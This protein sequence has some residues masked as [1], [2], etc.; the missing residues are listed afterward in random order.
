MING[1]TQS[2]TGCN[3]YLGGAT[4]NAGT[5][6]VGNGN[7]NSATFRGTITDSSSI[8]LFPSF[9][10]YGVSAGGL[11]DSEELTELMLDAMRLRE[12]ENKKAAAEAAGKSKPGQ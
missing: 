10:P 7:W 5:L 4:R 9:T 11:S 8:G 3:I 1:S 12:Q 6:Q 2:L